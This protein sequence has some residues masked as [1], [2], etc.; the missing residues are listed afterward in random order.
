MS[1]LIGIVGESGSGKSSSVASLNPKD[2]FIINIAGKPLPFK[3]S[4]SIYNS[5][6]KNLIDTDDWQLIITTLKNISEK[7]PHIKNIIIDDSQYIMAGEFMRRAKESGFVKF[8]EI[9]QHMFN[10]L[11]Q[12]KKL[13]SDIKVFYLTHSENVMDGSNIVSKKMKTIGN[14]IDSNITMEGLFTICLYTDVTQDKEGKAVYSFITNYYEK[15]PA[16]SPKGMFKDVKIEND[17]GLV[18]KLID[19]YYK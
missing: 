3:G 4:K 18:S 9:G 10:I 7:A 15:Y 16:K 11:D 14:M 5:E 8:A 13:R 17:L 1:E 19:D 2:T 12:S 6:N